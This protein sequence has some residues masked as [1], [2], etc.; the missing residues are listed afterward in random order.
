M[1]TIGKNIAYFRKKAG[2]TQEELSEIMNVTSQAISKWENDLSYLYLA[3]IKELASALNVSADELLNGEANYPIVAD[4][5]E[6]RIARRILTIHIQ[7]DDNAISGVKASNITV[8]YPVSVLMKSQKNGTLKEI[9]GDN[10]VS[11]LETALALVKQGITGPIVDVETYG[12]HV[13]ITVEDYE[14]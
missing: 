8:R 7:T 2:Y 10:A 14:N 3:G 4:A 13:K 11:Q 9:V 5:D 12:T 1:E 6:E